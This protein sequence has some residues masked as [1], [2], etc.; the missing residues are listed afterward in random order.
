MALTEPTAHTLPGTSA[1]GSIRHGIRLRLR[2]VWQRFR[3]R[4][5]FE[6]SGT[7]S[8]GITGTNHDAAVASDPGA[9]I[10]RCD[11]PPAQHDLPPAEHVIPHVPPWH[12][13]DSD[14]TR[15]ADAGPGHPWRTKV[16]QV[17]PASRKLRPDRVWK[18]AFV[19][20]PAC[21]SFEC[22][23]CLR[24]LHLI[25][26]PFCLGGLAMTHPTAPTALPS[27][28][29]CSSGERNQPCAGFAASRRRSR[30]ISHCG[31]PVTGNG[32]PAG[33]GG[34]APR[35]HAG[36]NGPWECRYADSSTRRADYT[37]GGGHAEYLAAVSDPTPR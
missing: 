12:S 6:F 30:A 15:R 17:R 7:F 4:A 35:S 13:G 26:I 10:R 29:R 31:G 9:R 25:G 27:R 2:R 11:L 19:A 22:F 14:S 37:G 18:R 20:R 21:G 5:D 8:V 32:Q 1:C 23:D 28:G 36:R 16:A 24:M 34:A 3:R 33:I